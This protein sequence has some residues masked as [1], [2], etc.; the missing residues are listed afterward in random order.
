VFD[1]L[2]G[3]RELREV[4]VPEERVEQ[5]LGSH[6]Q[7]LHPGVR[8]GSRSGPGAFDAGEGAAAPPAAEPEPEAA[9]ELERVV[10]LNGRHWPWEIGRPGSLLGEAEGRWLFFDLETLR[11]AD[12]V[13]GWQ[14]IRDMGL[15]LGV[16]FDSATGELRTYLE[17]DADRL[18]DDLLA[19]D[20]VVGFNSDRFDLT[21][22]EGYVGKKIRG[23]RSLDLL[24]EVRGKLGKRLSLA[25]LVGETL[26]VGKSADGL[27]SLRWVKQGRFDLI[28]RYCRD[29]VVLTTALWAHGRE[30]GYVLFKTKEGIRARVPVKW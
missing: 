17:E 18:A 22:L 19:A 29:D 23:V 10:A 7:V 15:A 6:R 2:L 24:V 25:H 26:G 30:R 4:D 16:V 12:D 14:N 5:A 8:G 11:S 21:V 9:G 27:Q 28:E 1:V 3:R 20:R 13:G